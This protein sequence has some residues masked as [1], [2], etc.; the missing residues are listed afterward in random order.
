MEKV[1]VLILELREKDKY[2]EPIKIHSYINLEYKTNKDAPTMKEIF[3]A[4]REYA[5]TVINWF[6]AYATTGG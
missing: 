4:E 6:F 2:G 1:I 5:G 3:H